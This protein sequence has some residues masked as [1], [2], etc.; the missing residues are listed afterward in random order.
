VCAAPVIDAPVIDAPPE[1]LSAPARR[2]EPHYLHGPLGDLLL[3]FAWV[4]FVVVVRI[5]AERSATGALAA[6]ISGVFL[7]SFAHQPLT[8]ALVYGDHENFRLRRAVFTWTPLIFAVAVAVGYNVNFTILAI[9]GGLWNAEH[10]LMQRYGVTRIYGRKVGQAGGTVEKLLLWSWLLLALVW[11]GANPATPAGLERVDFGRNNDEALDVLVRLAPVARVLLWPVLAATIV[12][13]VTWV[14]Q[15][16]RRAV[17]N[18]VK[19]LYLGAT[20]ALFALMLVDPLAGLMGY[21]GAH[22]IEYFVIVHQSLGRRYTSAADDGGAW[23]G[24]V[25]RARPGRLGFL[26]AYAVSIA[27]LITVLSKWG[28]PLVYAIVFFTLGGMHVFY[29]GFIWK[30]RR[31]AVAR[32]L[33]LPADAQ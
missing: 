9:I 33:A 21:I 7:L 8:V 6:V 24:R 13:V 11:A 19:W 3:A 28:S 22:A 31:P 29:D 4:P 10:T 15:E 12:L 17:V 16:R 1:V 26:S 2:R 18:P 23:L 32:S 5:L 20:A 27:V 30:L 14:V 25:V